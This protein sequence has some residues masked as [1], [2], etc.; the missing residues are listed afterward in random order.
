M[1]L[2]A[3]STSY[4]DDRLPFEEHDDEWLAEGK[5]LLG[6]LRKAV[7]GSYTIVVTE[8]WWGEQPSHNSAAQDTAVRARWAAMVWAVTGVTA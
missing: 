7:G 4:D 2:G 6:E 5:V 1:R 3:W 8:P